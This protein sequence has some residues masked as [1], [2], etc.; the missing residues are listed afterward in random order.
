MA[1]PSFWLLKKKIYFR[2]L[3]ILIYKTQNDI[4]NYFE[5]FL[6]IQEDIIL[7]IGIR[8]SITIIIM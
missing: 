3:I 8:Q 7:S 2:H 5:L 6:L 4:K 1:M